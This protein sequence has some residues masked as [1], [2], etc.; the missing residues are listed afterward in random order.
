MKE[1]IVIGLAKLIFEAK[2]KNVTVLDVRGIA[3]F[4]DYFVISTVNSA[5]HASGLRE[6]I[7]D[8]LM[9][10]GVK[11]EERKRR[12][13]EG[14]DW[15]LIDLGDAVVHLMSEEARTFYDLEGLWHRAKVVETNFEKE[16][17][18]YTV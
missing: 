11:L 3:S 13:S 10:C 5:A 14:G 12:V 7:A 4:T 9:E 18:S 2:G 1:E 8:Y 16:F 6:K 17:S 15:N